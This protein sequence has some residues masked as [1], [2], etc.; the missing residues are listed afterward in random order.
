MSV[1]SVNS[2]TKT[3]L[4]AE[5][6]TSRPDQMLEKEWLLTN[7]RG[8]FAAGT[9][10]SCNTR[11]YHGLLVASLTP[12]A[13]RIMAVSAC[14]EIISVDYDHFN[15]TGFE[16][17]GADYQPQNLK[18]LKHF[19]KDTGVHFDY[20]FDQFNLTKSIYLLPDVDVVAIVYDFMKL[21]AEVNFTARPFMALR[22]FHSLQN[23]DA[24][25][26]AQYFHNALLAK[27]DN[28]DGRIFMYSDQMSFQ[29][30]TQWWYDF[31]YR[32]DHRRCQD[33][34]EDLWTPGY[35]AQTIDK[36]TKI[37][38]WASFAKTDPAQ[39]CR[40]LDI[41]LISDD[42]A[43]RQKKLLSRAK[44]T[45]RDGKALALAAE[46]FV[47]ERQL[48]EEKVISILA[49]YPWFLDWGRDAFISLDGLLLCT[50]RFRE[51]ASVLTSFAAAAEEGMIPN[52]FDDYD[53]MA[54]YNSIDASLWFIKAAFDYYRATSDT[55]TFAAKLM[56]AIR[57]IIESYTNGTKFGIGADTDGLIHGGDSNTQLTW[58]DAKVGDTVF[59]PRHGKA[60]E[61]N[62]LWYNA[63]CSVAEFYRQRNPVVARQFETLAQKIASSFQNTFWYEQG[64]YLYDCIDD[65]GSPDAAIRPNQIFAVSLPYSPLTEIQ[66]I[67]VV[68]TVQEQLLTPFG[69]RTLAPGDVNYHGRY[70]GNMAQ[71][72]EAYHQ[73][74]VWPFLIGP[75]VEAYLRVNDFS[76]SAKQDCA[77]FIRPLLKHLRKEGCIGSIA[78]IFDGDEP[79]QPKGAFAQA[80]SIAQLLFANHLIND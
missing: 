66:K 2:Y 70:V 7:N 53:G 13:N 12:P 64:G 26:Q 60:V 55:K 14:Q 42:L 74:T 69:L 79:H 39:Q 62:A 8:S 36:P 65:D 6:Q 15:L 34:K 5:M 25:M 35:F 67:S 24:P 59:T 38:L 37:V 52:R 29:Q 32:I 10:A 68:K 3:S 20:K 31:S 57:W 30:E 56:P 49:G 33:Y 47:I 76:N 75:F 73:G 16:F 48:G 46:Q 51:A 17:T 54:H 21:T 50:G 58:M 71:R 4:S 72:D 19:C 44:K 61:I 78:E 43:L 11:R 22:D 27:A 1:L 28:C 40:D 80:W 9:L 77:G 41:D 63:I 18:Y 45:D 23:S